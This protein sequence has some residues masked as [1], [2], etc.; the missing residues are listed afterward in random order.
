MYDLTTD[1]LKEVKQLMLKL[2]FPEWYTDDRN[3]LEGAVRLYRQATF[4][5][6]DAEAYLIYKRAKRCLLSERE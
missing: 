3:R 6:M 2:D 1:E 5:N 4:H